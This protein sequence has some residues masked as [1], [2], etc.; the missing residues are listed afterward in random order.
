MLKV[1]MIGGS[2]DRR[3]WQICYTLEDAKG[4]RKIERKERGFNLPIERSALGF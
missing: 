2:G 4:I 3:C 1:E